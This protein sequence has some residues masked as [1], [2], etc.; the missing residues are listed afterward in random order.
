[1]SVVETFH[2]DLGLFKI[3]IQNW[4]ILDQGFT[5]LWGPSGA[6]KSTV[7][8]GLIGFDSDAQVKWVFK[9]E[10]IS[11]WPTDRR[12]LGVVFQDLFLFPHMTA[13]ENIL[14][15]VDKKRHS[16]WQKDFSSLVEVLQIGDLLSSPAPQLSGGERQRVALARALIYRPRML[17]L[18]EPFSSL[19]EE[20]K[21]PL[22][23]LLRQVC[24]EMKCPVLLVSHDP[25][26]IEVLANKLTRI[27]KGQIVEDSLRKPV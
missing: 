14:F 5:L 12:Q 3:Q 13:Q 10:E 1:M 18:D 26:D 22:R 15:P 17:L 21:G 11:R 23:L 20:I 2:R 7:L 8:N 4:E 19:N 25:L 9:G 16:H 24:D 6:G 27:E